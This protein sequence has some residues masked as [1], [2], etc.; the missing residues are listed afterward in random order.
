MSENTRTPTL[1]LTEEGGWLTVR[2][3][4]PEIRNALTREMSADLLEII[5]RVEADRTVRGITFRG[6]GQAFCAGGDLKAFQSVFQGTATVE[7][8]AAFS[9]EAAVVFQ[10]LNALPQVTVMRVEGA[11]MAGGFGLVCCGDIVLAHR[12]ARFSLTETR[13]G[14][15]P[16]Q[17]IPLVVERMGKAN[18][19]RVMLTAATLGAAEAVEL[20]LADFVADDG[21]GL[22]AHEARVRSQV[23]RCAP[24]AVAAT[25]ALLQSAYPRTPDYVARAAET[26]ATSLLGDEGR[27]GIASFI[28]RRKPSWAED[29]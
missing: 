6:E 1:V 26:F 5:D 14:L 22:D 24:G 9:R 7:E 21:A 4:R 12:E 29:G 28:G 8:I 10:R 23:L 25:K 19:R 17:I 11:A 15:T 27:E 3:N 16:A 2:F 20:G 18:A 13:I